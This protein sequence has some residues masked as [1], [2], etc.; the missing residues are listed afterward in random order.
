M[1]DPPAELN[2]PD[3]LA[4]RETLST[5]EKPRRGPTFMRT[6]RFRL[7]LTY[8][9]MLF[10]L[11]SI[12]LGV[13]YLGLSQSLEEQIARR[14]AA[15]TIT[16]DME[17]ERFD[18]RAALEIAIDA[19]TLQTLRRFSIAGLAGVFVA[20]F[21]AGWVASGQVLRPIG[22]IT[23]VARDIQATDLSRRIGLPGPEDDLKQ[24]ADT[25]D[26]MLGRLEHAFDTQQRLIHDT[27]H[28]LRNPLAVMRTNLEVT[29]SD[30]G[31]DAEQYRH[32]TEVVQRSAERMSKLVDDL[33]AYARHE[34]ASRVE[35]PLDVVP[36]ITG[37]V[38][39]F[40]GPAEKAGLE[41]NVITDGPLTV[42]GHALS[43]EQALANL[44]ANAVRFAPPDTSIDIEAGSQD[45]WVWVTVGDRGPG[46]PEEERMRV[47]ERY[48]RLGD[49]E[50]GRPHLAGGKGSGLGLAIV[51]EIARAHRGDVTLVD[52]PVGARFALWL[53]SYRDP[54]T[55][56]EFRL[57]R[58]RRRV[59]A[60]N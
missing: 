6:L 30:P 29:L 13:V 36:L 56:S 40:A 55:T 25:F 38:S 52:S 24:L 54:A 14:N 42:V 12:L 48:V 58:A 5:D 44:L 3:S 53:P 31:A 32:T 21:A 45:G 46:V 51:R 33:L 59:G 41:L 57:R 19:R 47:F 60:N 9:I 18:E 7:T 28:E 8:S 49:G 10:G 43:L 39:E 20:S 50:E 22:H 27:S 16:F 23:R 15:G 35:L 4:P 1:V 37:L 17:Q 34:A 26:D 2:P 11:A